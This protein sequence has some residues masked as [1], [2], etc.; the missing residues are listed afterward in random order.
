MFI[1]GP[2]LIRSPEGALLML[3]SSHG[4]AGYAMGIAESKV[5]P[6]WGPG[7]STTGPCGPATAATA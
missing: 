3:W 7:F 1:D 5:E 4:D 6:S 2:F